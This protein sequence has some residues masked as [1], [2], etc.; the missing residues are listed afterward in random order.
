MKAEL[1]GK[2]MTKFVC[3]IKR[4]LIFEIYKNCLEPTKLENKIKYLEKK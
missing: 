3:V 2:I 4:K 1:G